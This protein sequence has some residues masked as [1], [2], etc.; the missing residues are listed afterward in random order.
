MTGACLLKE[1]GGTVNWQQQPRRVSTRGSMRV[2]LR[3][4]LRNPL[5]DPVKRTCKGSMRVPLRDPL[6]N[7]LWDPV[8]RSFQGS[9]RVPLSAMP[10]MTARNVQLLP[11]TTYRALNLQA[12]TA[13]STPSQARKPATSTFTP[14]AE[15]FNV[16][17]M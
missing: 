3:D 2:P 1:E 13:H 15:G 7:P 16:G 6:R 12:P 4:P 17:M 5:R 14:K 11:L 8:K 9:T 10:S